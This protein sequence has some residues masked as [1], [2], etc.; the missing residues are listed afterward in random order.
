[1]TM[2]SISL[3]GIQRKEAISPFLSEFVLFVLTID[4][5][6]EQNGSLLTC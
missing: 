1:M 2:T 4:S 3:L 6:I 5:C